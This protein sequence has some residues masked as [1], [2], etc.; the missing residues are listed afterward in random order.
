MIRAMNK[1]LPLV[2]CC[3][4]IARPTLSDAQAV[5]LETLLQGARRP[6]PASRSSTCSLQAGGEAVCVCEFTEPL[7][8]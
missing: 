6:P 8:L 1:V 4:P 2:A 5:E 7:G 3:T